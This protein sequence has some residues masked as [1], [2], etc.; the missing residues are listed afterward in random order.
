MGFEK[1]F[2]FAKLLFGVLGFLSLVAYIGF[3]VFLNESPNFLGVFSGS[4]ALLFAVFL[5]LLID[6]VLLVWPAE[7]QK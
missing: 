5:F 4:N 7:K 1:R 6:S 2:R 3:R